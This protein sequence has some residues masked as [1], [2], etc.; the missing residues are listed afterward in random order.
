MKRVLWLT[1]WYP[2]S[3]DPYSGD[4]IQ[5]QAQAVSLFQPL[6][7]VYIGKGSLNNL[8]DSKIQIIDYSPDL[9]EYALYYNTGNNIFSRLSSL[10]TYLKKGKEIMKL[11]RSKN[12][13]PE[14]VHVHVAM[15]A[16]LL[17]VYLKWK[18]KIPYIVTEH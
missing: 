16:G 1:S 12:E 10:Y 3:S 9:R 6:N 8:P 13:W 5:R 11:L 7:V 2:N 15:K 14:I 4:F 17:A 18:Y